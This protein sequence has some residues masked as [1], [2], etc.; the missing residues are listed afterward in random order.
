MAYRSLIF[1]GGFFLELTGVIRYENR[2]L[3]TR[4]ILK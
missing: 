1:H 4:I 2:L 3:N